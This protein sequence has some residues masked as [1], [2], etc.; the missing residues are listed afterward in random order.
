[1]HSR[2]MIP[3]TPPSRLLKLTLL[4]AV[5]GAIA[6]V[7]AWVRALIGQ[8]AADAFPGSNISPGAFALVATAA[9]FGSATRA[10]F[11]SI[12][13]VF[14]L[15]RDYEAVLPL[16]LATVLAD[17]VARA[18]MADSLMTEKLTRR[19]VRVPDGYHPDVLTTTNVSE[20][21]AARAQVV[22]LPVTA[23][24]AEALAR[25][26]APGHSAYPV[27]DD[28]GRPVGIVSRD[29]L[30][31]VDA[32]GRLAGICTRTDVLQARR[33]Q[34]HLEQLHLEQL[35]LEQLQPGWLRRTGRAN[36]GPTD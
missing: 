3:L 34:L 19:G 26:Q 15:T 21:M 31:V 24:V 30:P 18:L 27:V 32:D 17:L 12:V 10:P 35:H 5:V 25:F 6:G 9:T 36:A 4:A 8:L 20:V 16:M 22:T 33:A 14:E 7:A 13:F 2:S 1:M 11:A 29:D 23:T 28:D